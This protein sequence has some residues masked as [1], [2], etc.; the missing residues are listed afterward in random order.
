[1]DGEDGLRIWESNRPDL[2]ISDIRMPKM[3]GYELAAAIRKRNPQQKLILMSGYTEDIERLHKEKTRGVPFLSKP[4]DL[5]TT[6]A[7][8]VRKVLAN[9]VQGTVL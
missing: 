9:R 6:L 7:Q 5:N 4:V 1:M 2:V 8:T 3:D